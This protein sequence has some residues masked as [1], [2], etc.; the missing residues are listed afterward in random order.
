MIERCLGC[1]EEYDTDYGLCPYCGYELDTEVERPIHMQPGSLLHAKYLVGRVLGYGGFGVTY[2]GWD[3]TL[4]QKVAIKEYLP[5]DLATRVIGQTQV[6]VFGGDKE[7]QFGDGIQKFIDEAKRLVQFQNESGIVRV[8]DSFAENNTAYIIMEYL[9]GE[10]LTAYL[11]RNGKMNVDDA[12]ALL[13]PV[14]ESMEKMHSVGIIHR[15]IAPDNIFLTKDGNVKLIDFGAA[16]YATPYHSRSLTVIIKPGYSPEE[17]YR[18][19]GEQGPHTDVYAISAVLYRMITGIVLPDSMERRAYMEKNGKDIVVPISKHCRISKNQENAI[20]NALN[21]RVED[22]TPTAAKFLEELT[23]EKPVARVLGK[24]KMLDLMRWPLWAK[25]TIPTAA[26]VLI[27]LLVLLLTGVIGG[28]NIV[29]DIMLGSNESRVPNIVNCSVDVAESRLDEEE[30]DFQIIGAQ[31]SDIVPEMVVLS[32]SIAPG[33][34]VDKNTVIEVYISIDQDSIVDGIM[35]SVVYMTEKDAVALLSTQNLVIKTEYVYDDVAAEGVVIEQSLEA[36]TSTLGVHEVVLTVSQGEDPEKQKV[37]KDVV[38]LKKE[39]LELYVGDKVNVKAEGG[40][41]TYTYKT[42]NKKVAIVDDK[43][44]V[45]AIAPGTVKIT[46]TSGKAK[47]AVCKVTVKDYEFTLN[48]DTVY[49]MEG[50][51]QTLKPAGIPADAELKW[52]TKDKSVAT[53]NKNGKVTAVANGETTITAKWTLTIP[54][55]KNEPIEKVYK[56]KAKI[57]VSNPKVVLSQESITVWPSHEGSITASTVPSDQKVTWS[58]DNTEI[59]TVTNGVIKGQRIGSTTVRASMEYKGKKYEVSCYVTVAE[60]S[61]RISESDISLNMGTSQDLWA[62]TEPYGSISWSS[63]DNRVATVSNGRVTAVNPGNA[64]ITAKFTVDG[65]NYTDTCKVTVKKPSVSLSQENL[66]LVPGGSAK[67]TAESRPGGYAISWSSSDSSVATV[68]DGKVK[69]VASG[70]A[71]ITAKITVNGETYKKTCT[72]T[73]EKP[74]VTITAD[75]N[76]IQYS[77]K[78]KGTCTVTAQSNASGGSVKWKS[79]DKS[80]ATVSGDGMSATVKAQSEGTVTI[81]ATYTVNGVTVKDTCKITVQKAAS[82]L[83]IKNFTYAQAGTVDNFWVTGT[84]S[85]NY[86]LVRVEAVGTATSNQ[87]GITV[88]GDP[89][90]PYY[91]SPGQF[92]VDASILQ[93]YFFEQYRSLYELYANVANIIGA[94]N[95][96]TMKM[97]ITCYDA[98]GYSETR[99]MTYVVYDD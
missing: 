81:T 85:S 26:V 17:Q 62:E 20:M 52:S 15:D 70:T 18:S 55:G 58:S 79:S 37:N 23:T 5:S 77:Q 28:G 76:T 61:I 30:L 27:T 48:K 84:I 51:N 22:R 83:T 24:I 50:E 12:V 39:K 43:G 86:E 99:E 65:E 14:L 35:P 89:A 9:E 19:K 38:S 78:K 8:L 82:T 16:R 1:M 36:G 32:Q 42:G 92:T 10:T 91:F 93:K 2:I 73:V 29:T 66:S 80:I 11:E 33:N 53:V 63:S 98:S 72:V 97:K 75:S 3:F 88:G 21:V 96:V 87:L 54:N 68:S 13:T 34:V 4:H 45:T 41:G 6:S 74:S 67:L 69:A 94:D 47:K 90:K 95:S 44:N 46:V 60:P 71:T 7:R 31:F 57:I 59:A 49:L 25:I 64:T 40:E 56:A